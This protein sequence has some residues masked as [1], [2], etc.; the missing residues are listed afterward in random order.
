M[1]QK[2]LFFF[3]TLGFFGELNPPFFKADVLRE[4]FPV[5]QRDCKICS[6][7]LALAGITPDQED[8]NRLLLAGE[9]DGPA[10]VAVPMRINL[11]VS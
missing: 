2:I 6:D 7:P 1:K 4:V 10:L 8:A 3:F 5:E 9:G 11:V